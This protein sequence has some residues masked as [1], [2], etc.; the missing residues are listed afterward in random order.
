MAHDKSNRA[1][2]PENLLIYLGKY[3]LRK[4]TGQEQDGKVDEVIIHTDYNYENFYS[5]IAVLKLKKSV[6]HTNQVRPVCLWTFNSD[7]KAIV[8]KSGEV[9]GWGYNENGLVSEEL[10]FIKM[11]VVTHETCI[12]S[13]RDFFSKITS[14]KSF[15]AGF[16]NGSSVW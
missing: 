3:N 2:N 8:G 14:E 9:P 11:P 12:W 6:L 4:W 15:C 16:R 7:L 5:D 1:I 13:N 10:S